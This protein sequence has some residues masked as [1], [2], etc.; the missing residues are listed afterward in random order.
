MRFI[1]KLVCSA[2]IATASFAA[3][4][5]PYSSLVVFGDSLSDSGNNTN[6]F[7]IGSD[8]SQV[9]SGNSYVPSFTYASGVY[10]NGPVWATQFADK[11]GLS[12]TP[13]VL[14]GTNYAFGGAQTSYYVPG[15]STPSLQMQT[16]MYIKK[17]NGAAD[18]TGLY[19]VAGGGNNLRATLVEAAT[20]LA[21]GASLETVGGIITAAAFQFATDIGD[22]VDSLQDAGAKN[23]IVWNAPNL[24]L[25][26]A[27][28]AGGPSASDLGT[29]ISQ[30]FNQVLAGHLAT[31]TDVKT[32]DLYGLVDQA[33]ASGFTNTKDA[34]GAANPACNTDM[35]KNLFW[36]GI[37]PTTAAHTLIAQNMMVTAVPEPETYLLM[38]MGL[39]V[40]ATRTRKRTVVAQTA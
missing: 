34:C 25:A 35:S 7:G 1:S 27:V 29:K 8:P 12:L 39:V 20:A 18:P 26:P 15:Q 9:I 36:D 31:E 24:G 21:S 37:H 6:L 30:S 10:S 22:I 40:I 19:V 32:F 33:T 3:S 4:A 17:T 23:I 2:I 16:G 14:G 28:A 11:L 38:A 13:S 5:G